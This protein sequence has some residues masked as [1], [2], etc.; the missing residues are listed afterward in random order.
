MNTT[1]LAA[2]TFAAG[3]LEGIKVLDLSR[4]LAGPY[5]TMLLGDMGASVIKVERPGKGDDTR[6]FGPPFKEGESAYFMSVNR[7]KLSIT[8]NLK[9]PRGQ[10]LA[11]EMACKSDV[12]VE[13]FRPGKVADLGLDYESIA[14]RNPTIVYCSISGFGQDG[15]YASRPGYD[16]IV[17]GMSGLMSFTGEMGGDPLKV[18]VAISDIFSGMTAYQGILLALLAREKTGKGQ[19]VDIS[20]LDST[21]SLLTYQGGRFFATGTPP[22]P[23]G[24]AHPTIAPYETFRTSDGFVNIAVGND[25]LWLKFC[26]AIGRTDLTGMDSF[27]TNALRVEHH[28]ELTT[29]LNEI[30]AKQTTRE[31]VDILRDRGVPC[32]AINTLADVADDPQVEHRQMVI[33]MD[34]PK[35]ESV[36]MTG[37]P[38]KLS[39]TPGSLRYPPPVL[40]EHTEY[41]L[42][43]WLDYTDSQIDEFRHE[44]II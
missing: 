36:S 20:M 14:R 23:L 16:L 34:H 13:N 3:A 17:Q 27:K 33:T 2:G 25:A 22:V 40:G 21:M 29:I 39:E 31:W 10:E 28:G 42:K 4:V 30:I 38:I 41:I 18:G 32:G 43:E 15:P 7:N 8:L 24:N 44:G 19:Y 6:Q 26:D 1:T 9:N 5:C 35:C 37:I 12:V 11:M